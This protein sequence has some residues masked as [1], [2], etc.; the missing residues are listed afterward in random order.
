MVAGAMMCTVVQ[1]MAWPDQA[2]QSQH[3][4][5]LTQHQIWQFSTYCM[6]VPQHYGSYNSGTFC[7]I[8][9]QKVWLQFSNNPDTDLSLSCL[10]ELP[11]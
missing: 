10:A 2:V 5:S 4:N 9:K 7:D 11:S 6:S 3:G 1:A 8:T